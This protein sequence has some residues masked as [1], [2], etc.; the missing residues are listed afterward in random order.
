MSK[1]CLG[2]FTSP[3]AGPQSKQLGYYSLYFSLSSLDW[4][5]LYAAAFVRE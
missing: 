2:A 5:D 1:T 4:L 3:R